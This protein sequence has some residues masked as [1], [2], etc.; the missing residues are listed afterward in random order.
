M[1][2]VAECPLTR[3]ERLVVQLSADGLSAKRVA[4]EMAIS[5]NTVNNYLQAARH[6]LRV[7]NIASVVATAMRGGWIS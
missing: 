4:Y 3:Q 2:E 6:K 1:S 7:N 5:K